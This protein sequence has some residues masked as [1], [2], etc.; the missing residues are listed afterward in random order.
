MAQPVVVERAR[1]EMDFLAREISGAVGLGGRD[2]PTGSA[3][4]RARLSVTRAIRLAMTRITEH[5]PALGEHLELAIH[6][7]TYCAYRPDPRA[8]IEWRQ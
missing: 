5:S 6:T 1:G 2:R 3:S 8:P 7:G 4:E